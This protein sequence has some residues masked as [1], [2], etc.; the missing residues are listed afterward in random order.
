MTAMVDI[1]A[2]RQICAT[3]SAVD[4]KRTIIRKPLELFD[5]QATLTTIAEV[6]V[7]LAGFTG[8]VAVLGSR[9][10]HEWTPEERL[11][12]RTLVETSLTALFLSFAPSVLGLVMTSESAVWRLA[13]LLLG[14]MHLASITMFIV[15]T[16]VAKPT[17]GQ[18]A[19][20][21]SGFSVILAHFLAAAGLLPWYAAIFILGLLQLVFVATFNFVLLLFP[22]EASN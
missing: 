9:R 12:L 11:Q 10:D 3:I 19:L 6:S 22:V 2:G 7:A 8:V 18:L 5:P 20:L 16:K 4:P 15:R 14:A 17:G 13:N 1:P 21:A